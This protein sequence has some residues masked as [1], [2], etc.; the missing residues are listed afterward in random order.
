MS[1]STLDPRE[2][3]PKP[4]FPKQQ[5]EHPGRVDKMNPIA[6]E[7]ASI[8]E[9]E[10]GRAVKAPGDLQELQN[11]EKLISTA[12][13]TFGRLDIVVNN[14]GYQMSH[15][16]IEEVSPEELE[17]TFRINVFT[18]FLLSQ[19]ALKKLK[20]GGVILNTTSIQAYDPSPQLAVYAATKDAILS[21]TKSM[22]GV[23]MKKGVRVNAVAPG[24]VWTPL[25]PSTMPAGKVKEFGANTD[26]GRPA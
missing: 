2:A 5:Q 9:R 18:T 7:T 6:E 21:L 17:H 3:G 19:A 10:G 22:A 24:P 14:A 26:F 25:I 12:V 23:A 15:G 4:P 16:E 20:P 8:I 13:Q 1:V 11:I